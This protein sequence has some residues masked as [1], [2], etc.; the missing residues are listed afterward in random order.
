MGGI[1][2]IERALNLRAFYHRIIAGNIANANTPNYKRKEIDFASE[3]NR[4]IKRLKEVKVIE[5]NEGREGIIPPDGNT[6]DLEKETV[7]L[8][9]NTL[10]YNALVQVLVKR[11]SMM[12]YII[13]EGKR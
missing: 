12:R 9:E 6:V 13:N 4:E 8:T 10:M 5:E 11:F 3:I 1:S 7:N 2:L